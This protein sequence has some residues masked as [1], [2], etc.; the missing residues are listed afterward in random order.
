MTDSRR[1]RLCLFLLL[2]TALPSCAAK[3][4]KDP[5]APATPVKTD[6]GSALDR[7]LKALTGY[8]FSGAVLVAQ[9]GK[10]VLAQG[11]GMADRAHAVPFTAD[12]L[13]DST[14]IIK[15]F[16]AAAI[17]RLEMAGKLKVEDPLS[18]FFPQA[19][20]DKAGI[21]LHQLLTHTSALPETVGEEYEPLS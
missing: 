3:A 5:P 10:V 4:P 14:S 8:G 9:N 15:P 17:L 19:P 20:P 2:A 7:D 13:F 6:L 11:Y 18:R 12:P 16:T 21:T 1:L